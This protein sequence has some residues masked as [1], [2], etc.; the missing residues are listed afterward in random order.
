MP[1]LRLNLI[2]ARKLD[3]EGYTNQFKGGWWK[4]TKGF[5]VIARGKRC[6]TLYHMQYKLC[7]GETCV[8]GQDTI[9]LWPKR[10]GHIGRKGLQTLIKKEMLPQFMD[11]IFSDCTYCVIGK[12]DRGALQRR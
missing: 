2:S 9:D 12:Q 7:E 10:L 5:L 1:N 3:G 4:L 11:N 8:V 6:C